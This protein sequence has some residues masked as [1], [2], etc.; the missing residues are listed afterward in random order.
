MHSRHKLRQAVISSHTLLM[1]LQV[2]VEVGSRATV[3]SCAFP[4]HLQTQ[5]EVAGGNVWWDGVMRY[6][7]RATKAVQPIFF[8][9]S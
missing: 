8:G 9:L 7:P 1:H 2:E 6:L 3:L 4:T 5:V